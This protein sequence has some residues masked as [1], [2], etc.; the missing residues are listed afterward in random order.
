[1][2]M[3]RTTILV[4]HNA[5]PG[6]PHHPL[7]HVVVHLSLIR[8]I[9]LFSGKEVHRERSGQTVFIW[10][11]SRGAHDQFLIKNTDLFPCLS[12]SSLIPARPNSR[13]G[14]AAATMPLLD[15]LEHPF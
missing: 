3:E 6:P 10:M 8:M 15:L 5:P 13:P 4:G 9:T 7:E 1:M 12:L 14:A 11:S 2:V